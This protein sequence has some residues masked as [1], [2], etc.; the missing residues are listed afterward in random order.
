[1]SPARPPMWAEMVS[2]FGVAGDKV[3]MKALLRDTPFAVV[4]QVFHAR[5]V[6]EG[7]RL[8]WASADR[9]GVDEARRKFEAFRGRVK[10]EG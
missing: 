4:L 10:A 7:A 2:V 5:A 3:R 1:M 8:R 6:A 9:A